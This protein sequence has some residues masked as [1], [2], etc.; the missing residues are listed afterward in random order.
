VFALAMVCA[1]GAAAGGPAC[2]GT[3]FGA[4]S[5]DV[6]IF[7]ACVCLWNATADTTAGGAHLRAYLPPTLNCTTNCAGVVSF[8]LALNGTCSPATG[9]LVYPNP[10][11]PAHNITGTIFALP[12]PSGDHLKLTGYCPGQPLYI[13]ASLARV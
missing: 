12:P 8:H 11:C 5:Y 2:D 9:T 13:A 4:W 10:F 1:L 3:W 7:G 6:G